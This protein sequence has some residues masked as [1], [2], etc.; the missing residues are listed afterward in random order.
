M[1]I[2]QIIISGWTYSLNML[3]LT[4]YILL[5]YII[6]FWLSARFS[7]GLS[8]GLSSRLSAGWNKTDTKVGISSP[9]S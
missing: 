3:S 1:Y 2:Y 5:Y 7:F 8:P 6:L 4:Q 9:Q